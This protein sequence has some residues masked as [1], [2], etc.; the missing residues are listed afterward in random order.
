[1]VRDYR[2]SD[3]RASELQRPTG[4]QASTTTDSCH[5]VVASTA[6]GPISLSTNRWRWEEPFALGPSLDVTS[7]W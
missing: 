7:I 4:R 6:P 1:M 5:V 3:P 2:G